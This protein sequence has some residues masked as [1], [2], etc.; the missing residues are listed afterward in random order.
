MAVRFFRSA[1][2]HQNRAAPRGAVSQGTGEGRLHDD[3]VLGLRA[4]L[5]L[6]RDPGGAHET[7][8]QVDA[9]V[10]VHQPAGRYRQAIRRHEE[11]LGAG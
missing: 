11:F 8:A 1:D 5:P 3:A 2:Q 10:G 7:G 6:E 4:P 9:S